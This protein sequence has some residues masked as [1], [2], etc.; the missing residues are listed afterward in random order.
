MSKKC[1]V[2]LCTAV[3]P[4]RMKVSGPTVQAVELACYSRILS[5]GL[6][7]LTVYLSLQV[8]SALI[9][10]PQ[11]CIVPNSVELQHNSSNEGGKANKDAWVCA[12]E[13][14]DDFEA[15][16]FVPLTK[17]PAPIQNADVGT[18]GRNLHRGFVSK[19]C[20]LSD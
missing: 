2:V 15:F 1:E 19:V 4:D 7:V 14:M 10:Q 5:D 8:F 6:I 17:L 20:I 11:L 18:S 16:R 3:L 12:D 9:C 13:H